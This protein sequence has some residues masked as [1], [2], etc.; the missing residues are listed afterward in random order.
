MCHFIDFHAVSHYRGE[1]KM[2]KMCVAMLFLL[3]FPFSTAFSWQGNVVKVLDG[4]S[5]RV[6]KGNKIIEVRLYGID[7]PEWGQDYGTKAKQFTKK[8]LLHKK[9][10]VQPF[11]IDRYGRTVALVTSSDL[12]INRELVSKGSAWVYLKYC[13]KQPLCTELEKLEDVAR[14]QKRGLWKAKNPVSPWQWKRDKNK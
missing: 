8:K 14:A 11:D 13:H 4:D 12:L 9:V 5:I 1:E 3:L 6:K 7:C 10:T 2:G